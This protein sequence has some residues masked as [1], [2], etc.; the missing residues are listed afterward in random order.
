MYQNIHTHERCD[1]LR[2]ETVSN[3]P[4]RVYVLSNGSRWSEK[5][6][7][8]HWRNL[9]PA[10]RDGSSHDEKH[11]IVPIEQAFDEYINAIA[12]G[13]FFD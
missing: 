9:A 10:T 7:F 6:F 4:I 12:D 11:T 5:L 3:P 8:R 2:V 1:V 13:T